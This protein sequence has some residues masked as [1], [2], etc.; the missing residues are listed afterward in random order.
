[1]YDM[2]AGLLTEEAFDAAIERHPV[3]STLM[4]LAH[5]GLVSCNS[6]TTAV[7]QPCSRV[8]PLACRSSAACAG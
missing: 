1:M 5:H 2:P 7:L 4:Q 6:A 3:R 8:L